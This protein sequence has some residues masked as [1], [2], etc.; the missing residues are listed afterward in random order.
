MFAWS[1]GSA[2]QAVCDA[3]VNAFSAIGLE[4]DHWITSITSAGAR[5]VRN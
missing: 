4:S 2:A 5:I 3:M 1:E